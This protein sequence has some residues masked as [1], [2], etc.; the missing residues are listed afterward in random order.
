MKE[1][2][3]QQY[4]FYPLIEKMG[5][6]PILEKL[7]DMGYTGVEFCFF[8]GFDAL[9]TTG[10]EFGK[11]LSDI[12]LKMVGNHFDRAVFN[13]SYERAF[14]FIAEAGGKY[15]IYNL[16]GPYNTMDD[17]SSAAEYIANVG[18]IAKKCGIQLIYH[19][20]APEFAMMDGKL[21]IDHL[22]ERFEGNVL[23]E[24][25]V[26][27]ASGQIDDVYGYIRKN[28]EKIR[29]VHFKQRAKDG[30]I[31]DLPDGIVDMAAVRDAATHAT[32]FV[33]EQH[34]NFPVSIMDSLKRN[35]E[36]LKAL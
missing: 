22:F 36:F 30:S 11:R 6:M 9:N 24:T 13:G 15:A 33:L 35:A 7:P 19:N 16:W 34:D 25:D 1:F 10:K 31:T 23:L 5:L 29:V 32:D 14:D 28:A 2:S 21:I 20:H 27:F 8:S 18:K 3:V 26:Y 12:G 4:T 17:I